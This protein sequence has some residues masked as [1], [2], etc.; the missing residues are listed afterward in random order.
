LGQTP[1]YR[2][3]RKIERQFGEAKQGHEFGRCRYI[4]KARFAFQ[5]FFHGVCLESQ[6]HDERVTGINFKAGA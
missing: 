3:E 6:A 5:A 1:Q 4:G 2:E